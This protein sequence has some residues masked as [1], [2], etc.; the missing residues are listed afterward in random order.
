MRTLILIMALAAFG[1]IAG[2]SGCEQEGKEGAMPEGEAGIVFVTKDELLARMQGGDEFVLVDVLG[3]DSFKTNHIKGAIN[4]PLGSIEG[5][6]PKALNK[7]DTIM[8]YCGSFQCPAST[9]A[10][11]KLMAM[12]YT[13]VYDYKGGLKEWMEAGLP[14][15]SGAG[16]LK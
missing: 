3:P 6:A 7:D 5:T 12:G 4:I 1:V 2:L 9:A 13:K 11:E 10:A 8:V 14:V 16:A 15:E